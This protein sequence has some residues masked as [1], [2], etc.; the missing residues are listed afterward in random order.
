MTFSVRLRV[1]ALLAAL[2]VPNIAFLGIHLAARLLPVELIRDRVARALERGDILTDTQ[3]FVVF[4]STRGV[5]PWG[6]ANTLR[7][8]IYRGT[9][10]WRDAFAPRLLTPADGVER[11]PTQ[12]LR[13]AIFGGMA[14]DPAS[15]YY[16]RYWHGNVPVASVLLFLLDVREARLILMQASYFLFMLLAFAGARAGGRAALLCLSLAVMGIWFSSLPY[17]GQTFAYAPAF[18]WSQTVA[19]AGLWRAGQPRSPF[20]LVIL[21]LILGAVAAFLEPMSGAF[22]LAA[23][24][25]FM[26]V[27]FSQPGE[28]RGRKH[29]GIA[30]VGGAALLAGM[31]SSLALKQIAAALVFGAGPVLGIFFSKLAWR[32]GLSG[33]AVSFSQVVE[34][35]DKHLI[36]LTFGSR[37]LA[38]VLVVLTATAAAA[39]AALAVLD[40][41]RNGAR[42]RRWDYI[43]LAGSI[44]LVMCWY[45][46]LPSHT[47]I[48]A[49]ITVRLLYVPFA[50]CWVGLAIAAEAAASIKHRKRE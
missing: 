36:Y 1:A 28:T 29:L 20:S 45:A 17:H 13:G 42:S 38:E 8:A 14:F 15:G 31:A 44:A 47:V 41:R 19:L 30:A 3:Q 32:I 24:L 33:E 10:A 25:F 16:H 48:H 23:C 37:W 40:I 12:E 6:D 39:A 43:A 46:A 9:S 50:L 26:T 21:G 2:L 18:I 4:D 34:T 11:H 49:W 35:L 5:E 27:Y 7:M 22:V